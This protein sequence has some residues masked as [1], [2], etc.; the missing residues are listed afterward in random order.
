MEKML[1][2]WKTH[3]KEGL[4]LKDAPIPNPKD[5]EVLV[6]VK[7]TSIC[8][9]DNH[10]YKWDE[11]AQKRI[12]KNIPYIFGHEV[13]GEVISAG[14]SAKGVAVGDHVSAETHISCGYC[15][16]CKTG[17]EHICR[18]VK[19]LGVDTNGTFAEYVTI[20]CRNA[21]V[22]DKKIPHW[23]ATAQ[24]PLGNAV[25]TVFDGEVAGKTITVFGMGP[26]GVCGV[27][28]CK[29]A[30]AEKVIAIDHHE[31]RLKFGKDFGADVIIQ[32]GDGADVRKQIMDATD[33]LGADVFLEFAGA[34]QA[35][36]DG[37]ATLRPGGRASI[38]GVFPK[39]FEV[40]VTNDIVF[41]GIR[42][43][44]INGRKMFD[45]WY[46][47]RAFLS[48]GKVKLEK[49][50]THRFKLSEIEKGFDVLKRREG[51]KVV[52]EP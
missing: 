15:Y 39:P 17:N 36:N 24:E 14:K 7:A 35:F 49:L 52:L 32:S 11:W 6:K 40:D 30:G 5:D 16:Q 38:L 8:G 12:G 26:I 3:P 51:M 33:G 45:T 13:S 27:A 31:G 19:I 41:R 21:W 48:S 18:N 46:K 2:V 4:E 50:V 29:A 22:N 37:I 42:L 25:H 1:S 47:A 43:S 28:L 23:V 34:P 10:I 20:P 44:G 9:T